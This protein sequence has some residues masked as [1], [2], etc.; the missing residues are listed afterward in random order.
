MCGTFVFST[1]PTFER[2]AL[3]SG[4]GAVPGREALVL[5]VE[6]EGAAGRG[7]RDTR[8]FL[9]VMLA[10]AGLGAPVREAAAAAVVRGF[11]GSAAK[12]QAC[13]L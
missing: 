4:L 9:S 6:E 3:G 7:A 5:A 12:G 10:L 11:G 13:L 8:V 1:A 2:T